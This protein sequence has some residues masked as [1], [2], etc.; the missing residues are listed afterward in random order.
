MLAE[1]G[2]IDVLVNNA[3]IAR[4]GPI[5]EARFIEDMKEMMAV[6]VCGTV[7]CTQA[8]LPSMHYKLGSGHIVT[9]TSVVGRKAFLILAATRSPCKRSRPSPTR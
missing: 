7:Y 2:R 5:G 1:C 9:M 3:G 6:D 8:V 4:V